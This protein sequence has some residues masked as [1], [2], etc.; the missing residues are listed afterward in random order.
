MVHVMVRKSFIRVVRIMHGTNTNINP[1][2][3]RE[4]SSTRWIAAS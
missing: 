3:Y 4:I 1:V 2:S